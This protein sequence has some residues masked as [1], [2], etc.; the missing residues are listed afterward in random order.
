MFFFFFSSKRRHTSFKCDWSS[1]VCSSDLSA[2]NSRSACSP[3]ARANGE[4]ADR[5]LRALAGAPLSTRELRCWFK[6]YEIGRAS[7]RE[8][9]VDLGGRRIIKKKNKKIQ[10][11]N[12]TKE[13]NS[14]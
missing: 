3:L 14:K 12:R 13:R 8:K 4:H 11:D 1:D 6:H 10:I 7:G 5:L 9:R 2:R